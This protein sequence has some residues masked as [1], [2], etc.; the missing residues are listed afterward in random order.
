[1]ADFED[2]PYIVV[3]KRSSGVT[4]FLWGAVLGAGIALL[5]APRSGVETRREIRAGAQRLRDSVEH[6]VRNLQHSI[7]GT[8][9]DLR[10]QVAEQVDVA[11]RAMDAGRDAARRTRQELERR[12]Q[13]AQRQ[14]E[15]EMA[16]RQ[17][18]PLD[19]LPDDDLP[20]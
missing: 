19:A 2:L 6:S 8:L 9:D 5:L 14:A 11:R 15:I 4:P 3:E 18:A 13:Y 16:S 7:A 17:G 10:D 1:M 20:I 12:V